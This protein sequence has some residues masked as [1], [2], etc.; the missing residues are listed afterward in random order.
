MS[1]HLRIARPVTDP[2]RTARMYCEGLALRVLG[3]FENHAGFDG[4]MVG[5]PDA[6]FH[7]EFTRCR[8]HPVAPSPT[9]EDLVVAYLPDESEW[10]RA[11]DRLTDAGF[12]VV[13][14]FNPYWDERGRTFADPDGY[15]VVLECAKWSNA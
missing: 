14:S 7:F 8:D 1:F 9:P 2:E 5:A 3:S 4:I 15:R 13:A 10:R 11:C 12:E 6:A